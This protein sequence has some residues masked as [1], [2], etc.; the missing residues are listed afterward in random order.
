MFKV[1]P[2]VYLLA[3]IAALAV[4]VPELDVFPRLFICLIRGFIAGLCIKLF[5]VNRNRHLHRMVQA[6]A[7]QARAIKCPVCKGTNLARDWPASR[8]SGLEIY[9]C[10]DCGHNS[11]D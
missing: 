6:K 9:D 5:I 10:L 7:A 4:N 11:F 8:V 3:A 1:I 2:N